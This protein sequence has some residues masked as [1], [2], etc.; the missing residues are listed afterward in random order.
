MEKKVLVSVKDIREEFPVST[1]FAKKGVVKALDG[2]S[3]DIYQGE[4]G[5]PGG[6]VRLRKIHPGSGHPESDS[7]HLRKRQL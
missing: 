2:I 4:T 3:F 7:C 5:R 1:G 6:R